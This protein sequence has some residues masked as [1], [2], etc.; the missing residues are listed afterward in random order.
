MPFEIPS[1]TTIEPGTYKAQL[2]R[3]DTDEGSFGTYRKWYWLVEA[4]GKLESLSALTSAHTGPR[5]RSYQWLTALL[6]RAPQAGEKLEDPTGKTV[7][8]TVGKNDKG[9]NT[10]EAV[11]PL[12][13]PTQVKE[14]IP[15]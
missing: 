7:L 12:V 15:R 9:F 1:H 8:V 10:V 11:L 6:G 13:D 3:V 2:E 14:G 5:S 4:D